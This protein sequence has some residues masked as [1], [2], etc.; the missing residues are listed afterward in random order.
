MEDL[1]SDYDK[2]I[3]C[4]AIIVLIIAVGGFTGVKNLISKA[5][6]VSSFLLFFI[7]TNQSYAVPHK[8]QTRNILNEVEPATALRMS[9]ESN[10]TTTIP[11]ENDPWNNELVPMSVQE[12]STTQ[13]V[14]E[15]TYQVKAGDNL[16]TLAT[17]F[18]ASESQI[19]DLW[20]DM[21]S[22]NI[23]TLISKNPNL[24]YPGEIIFIP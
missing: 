2:Y 23:S 21:I 22:I 3:I 19:D 11:I 15:N 17:Q 20:L 24:I 6:A 13:Y 14:S 1:M 18:A 7:N 8:S 9:E 4:T 12:S 10:K 16:Y 5:V